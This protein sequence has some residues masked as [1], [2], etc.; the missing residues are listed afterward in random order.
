MANTQL[1][2]TNLSNLIG[3][4]T[5]QYQEGRFDSQVTEMVNCIPS[6]TRGVLR[7]N[8]LQHIGI[9]ESF[10]IDS[11]VYAYDRGTTDEQ[12]IIVVDNTSTMYVYNANNG[13]ELYTTTNTYLN[14]GGA[15]PKT[16][17]KALT[18]GDHTFIVNNTKTPV[19]DTSITSPTV[20]YADM[21]FY[22]VKKTQ[23]VIAQQYQSSTE[24]GSRSIGYIY[25]IDING[26][27]LSVEGFSDTRPNITAYAAGTTYAKLAVSRYSGYNY[28]SLQD[29]NIGHQPNTSP[30]WWAKESVNTSNSLAKFFDMNTVGVSDKSF[31]YKTGG[32]IT[33]WESSDSF[34]DQASLAVWQNIK[35]SDELPA[36][37]PDDLDGFVVKVSGGTSAEF[38]DYYLQYS[39]TS[40]TWKEV[41]KPGSYT[42]LDASTMP[43][44]LYR[45]S[46][47]WELNTYQ[48]VLADGSA[49]EGTS[50]WGER[51]SGGDD[52]LEDPSFIGTNIK[53]IF[54]YKNRLG[55]LTDT[56]VALSRTGDYGNFFIQTLQE[57]LDDDPID[58]AVAS[59]NVTT[60]RHAV[61]T[62]GQLILFS[63]DTQFSLS[64][65]DGPL[66]PKSADITALSSYTYG[67]NAPAKA[68]GNRVFFTNQ[69]GGSSQ[70]YSYK[71]SDQGSQVTEAVPMTLHLPTYLPDTLSRIVGHDVL[72]FVFFEET[73]SPKQLTVLTSVIRGSEELQNSFHRWTF[74]HDI[75]ATNIINNDL[76]ILF[77]DGY[78]TKMSLA[79]PSSIIG[80]DYNDEYTDGVFTDYESKITFSE[81]FIR[82]GNGKGTS[83]GRYQLR[84]MKHTIAEGSSYM[85]TIE[86]LNSNLFNPTTMFNPI[87]DDTT[88]W[89]DDLIWIDTNPRYVR[90]YID[91]ELAT[92]MADSKRVKIEFKNSTTNPKVGFELATTN[93]EGFFHQR[94]MRR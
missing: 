45:L 43:H 65:L 12:Y 13:V 28:I 24:V 71:I 19:M 92:I 68:I 47:G 83:R 89:N 32:G 90:E 18:I 73:T 46:S 15:S 33:K 36:N 93:L 50:K 11:F 35:D 80:V 41:P 75:I 20:G 74:E 16:S 53:N 67:Q 26:T 70:V 86:D 79:V 30:D 17:F 34:G 39:N 44:V 61:P 82:D 54:F 76:Y 60:L 29:S 72:G 42:T 2:N 81:F 7:R 27:K 78:L 94:S 38:D 56:S 9:V 10:P 8:P 63:D 48:E 25:D 57:V 14:T 88:N 51:E 3:G 37:L 64:S 52:T 40:K 23:S 58:L 62:A 5:E 91:D 31:M 77:V 1:I 55:F 22:W 84:T 85:T 69:V 21:A 59:T 49:L 87:W 66:T 4:V 6:I